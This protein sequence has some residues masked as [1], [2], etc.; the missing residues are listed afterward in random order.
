M[1]KLIYSRFIKVYDKIDKQ[2]KNLIEQFIGD[3]SKY[4][5]SYSWSFKRY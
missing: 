4:T 2:W 3:I 5:C 1:K